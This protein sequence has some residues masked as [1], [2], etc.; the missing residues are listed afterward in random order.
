LVSGNDTGLDGRV[1]TVGANSTAAS[2]G[3]IA[4]GRAGRDVE[5]GG[6]NESGS[7]GEVSGIA[8]SDELVSIAGESIAGKPL[9]EVRW[10]FREKANKDGRLDLVF[11]RHGT[12][13][14]VSA[15]IRD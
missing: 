5:R 1:G 6:A 7:P 9:D 11:L 14:N 15:K 12:K 13:R 2:A 10:L 3:G 4:A 8:V